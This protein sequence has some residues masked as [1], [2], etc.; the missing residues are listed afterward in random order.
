MGLVWSLVPLAA[1]SGKILSQRLL[2]ALKTSVTVAL[3]SGYSRAPQRDMRIIAVLLTLSVAYPSV[4][5]QQRSEPYVQLTKSERT[6]AAASRTAASAGNSEVFRNVTVPAGKIVSFDSK[7]DYSSFD[8]VAV[9][10]RCATC[11]S[12]ANSL[13]SLVLLPFWSV[14]DAD[15][16]SVAEI[17][18]GTAFPYWDAGGA[19]FQVYGSEFRLTLQNTGAQD[20][21]IQQVTIFCRT[22]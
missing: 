1:P 4:A 20:I 16:Y 14:P 5:E 18:S 8:K 11:D 12:A 21:T 3:R 10:V 6:G 19:V 9:T 2:L 22:L 15:L 7:L 17:K 13:N